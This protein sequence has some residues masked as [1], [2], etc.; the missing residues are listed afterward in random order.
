LLKK[1]VAAKPWEPPPGTWDEEI[2]QVELAEEDGRRMAY[3]WW[4]SGECTRF[5]VAVMHKRAPQTVSLRI[6]GRIVKDLRWADATKMLKV[7]ETAML[8]ALRRKA[9]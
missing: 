4:A 5:P 7:Y 1:Q 3:V 6:W 9:H 8:Q 2:E